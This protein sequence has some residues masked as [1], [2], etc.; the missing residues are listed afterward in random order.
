MAYYAYCPNR[1]DNIHCN[2]WWDGDKPCCACGS[3]YPPPEEEH[4]LEEG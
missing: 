3:D 2:C 1:D 4:S